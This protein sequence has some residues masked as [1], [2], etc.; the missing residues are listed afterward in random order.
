[1]EAQ[2]VA[3]SEIEKKEALGYAYNH[4]LKGIKIANKLVQEGKIDSK[5]AATMKSRLNLNVAL[6]FELEGRNKEAENYAKAVRI[7]FAVN[8]ND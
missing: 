7:V 1:M 6:S 4:N 3:E 8:A 5:E 2:H